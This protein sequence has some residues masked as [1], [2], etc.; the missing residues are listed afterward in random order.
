MPVVG[1]AQIIVRPVFP[2][3][4]TTIS[5]QMPGFGR[6]AG[7][8]F[9]GGFSP[10]AQRGA[11]S[12]FGSKAANGV[13]RTAQVTG[14][15][16]GGILAFA[17]QRGFSRL[18]AIEQAQAKLRGLG[19]DAQ[20]IQG[21]MTSALASVKGTAFGL[22]EA[23]TAAASA[24]AA[25]IKPGQ[26]L[27]R[28]LKLTADAATI[29]GT[30]FSDMGTIINQVTTAGRAQ[31]DD[32]NQLADRGIPIY[33]WLAKQYGVT[34][35]E[36][37]KM[38][39]DGKVDAATFRKV[40][41]QNIGGAA[42]SAGDTTQGAFKNMQASLGR[43]GA[44][45]LSGL[46]P[47]LRLAFVG[48]T[49][50]LGPV[51]GKAK[52]V[53]AALGS[54]IGWAAAEFRKHGPDV[55]NVLRDLFASAKSSQ[56]GSIGSSLR[57]IGTNFRDM[58]PAVG[59]LRSTLP[60][61]P[62]LISKIA[63]VTGFLA[64]HSNVLKAAIVGLAAAF[65]AHKAAMVAN[66]IIGRNSAAGFL[67]Q[68]G[69]TV[70]LA[71]SNYA[72]ARSQA[73]VSGSTA[74]TTVLQRL[75]TAATVAQSLAQRAAGVAS[76]IFSVGLRAVGF[77]VRFA[78]GPVGLIIT[79]VGLLAAGLVYA[80][81]NSS[82]FRS[83]VTGAWQGVQA[84]VAA[85][86]GFLRDTVLPG[87]V[88]AFRAIGAGA[89][90]L[91]RNA[92][93][94]AWAG[95]Q[96]GFRAVGNVVQAVWRGFL[97]PVFQ[98]VGAIV[99]WLAQK[100]FRAQVAFIVG[101]W[102]MLGGVVRS[103]WTGLVQP[104]LQ[105]F[106]TAGK[107]L[108]NNVLKP[109]WALLTA[110]WRALGALVRSRYNADVKPIL[111]AFGTAAKFL[112]EK[113][114]QPA[115]QAI[116]SAWDKTS[117]KIK[118]GYNDTIKPILGF[119]GD[120]VT[121]LKETFRKAVEA[122]G[123]AW[124]GLR[125]A[126]RKPVKFVIDVIN[127]LIGG[128]DGKSGGFNSLAKKFGTDTISQ[129]GY[130]KGLGFRRGGYTGDGP[131]D[132]IAGPVHRRE[133]VIPAESR[134][135]AERDLPGGLDYLTR[136]G[137]WPT[138]P[139]V[140]RTAR[141]V[142]QQARRGPGVPLKVGGIPTNLRDVIRRGPRRGDPT[143]VGGPVDFGRSH[144][145]DMGWYR[146][147]LAFVNAAWNY[148]VGRFRT[149]TARQSMNAGPRT[150]TGTPPAGAAAYWD[151]G[152]AGHVALA[153]GDGTVFSNDI[154]QASRIDR[155]PQREINKWGPYR[156]WWH[157]SGAS[158]SGD[159]DYSGGGLAAVIDWAA[160]MKNAIS[161]PLAK[162]REITGT[163][164]GQMVASLPRKVA[165]GAIS[166]AKGWAGELLSDAVGA[167][168]QTGLKAYAAAIM[169]GH[170]WNPLTQM[171]PLNR[172]WEKESGWRVR[173]SNPSSGAYGI[174]QAL[175]GSKMASAGADWRTSGR[176]QIRWGE[177]YIKQVYGN[178]ARAW[179]HS[180]RLN[181]YANGTA[182]ARRGLAVIGERQ[183]ELVNFRGGEQVAASRR[184]AEQI[185]GAGP[186]GPAGDPRQARPGQRDRGLSDR[187][188][189]RCGRPARY[190]QRAPREL[191]R[192]SVSPC[193]LSS[194]RPAASACRAAPWRSGIASS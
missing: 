108:W 180:Q 158:G 92:I 177:D 105:A 189:R 56:A 40:I 120:K 102:K 95:I 109:T 86:W 119:L 78:L 68:I 87:V 60:S 171:G 88:G 59:E 110:G 55:V 122:I 93:A 148:T 155:V 76:T 156:G 37:R 46:F 181:W 192:R 125:A 184:Q 90:W 65:V 103:V 187:Y 169:P 141:D 52:V 136:T 161:K 73:A 32:L 160:R 191:A 176:T 140:D 38:V 111:S 143:G 152:W 150:M 8:S 5:K 134:T 69:S 126:A 22:D 54:A 9:A 42:L 15:A 104:T 16:V 91:W 114:L 135:R 11:L 124:D 179:A 36:L 79:A 186:A 34:A 19:H 58:A 47:Q 1:A 62:T 72:L 131:L 175:P 133:Q 147:C 121:G 7:R 99:V 165:A 75:Q 183:P 167:V 35:I 21:I 151:T 45:L 63:D 182:N 172:L 118:S 48:I 14:A 142:D 106:A 41:E 67:L 157:P 4:Q 163:P 166:K 100:I 127:G 49:D 130:P 71:A 33:Q 83:I 17:I 80:W 116:R 128:T 12:T 82:T 51:E 20:S 138:S 57:T 129:I 96:A 132:E 2:G 107:W 149:A 50:A 66:E 98:L 26:E 97:S 185:F 81:R 25:G 89:Q 84:A 43:V 27:T 146:R 64:D 13:K 159:G 139:R 193:L 31:T 18:N 70:A 123:R 115:W 178:P 162:L 154:R 44:N 117:G 10:E 101:A 164:F 39:S 144:V 74:R 173:A 145:G 112:W 188:R 190:P 23:A 94:P 168:K 113:V 153:A 170:G 77:A 194:S 3:F 137:R 53:G 30:S 85:V 28:Y 61:I 24:V 29:A 6:T 174:P